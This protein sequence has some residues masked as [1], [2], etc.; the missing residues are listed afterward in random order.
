MNREQFL[1]RVRQAAVSGRRY[2]V[3]VEPVPADAGYVGA[4][5]DL[6]DA[7]AAEV[8]LVGGEPIVV[9]D[10]SAGSDAV[11]HLLRHYHARSV[12]CWEHPVLDR[13]RISELL[14][15]QGAADLRH[16]QLAALAEDERRAAILAADLGISSTDF[17]I[18]ETGTLAVFAGPGHER[19][20]SLAPPVHLAIVTADQIIPDLFDLFRELQSRGWNRLPSNVTLISGPSKTGDIELELTTGIHGPGKWHVLIVR[21]SLQIGT[22]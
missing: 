19:V 17:A 18:A 20:I 1:S 4:T 3:H 10:W 5:G 14:A 22:S 6:C 21:E 13:L 8:A 16:S 7:L 9:P 2:R 12:L 11:A 15:E